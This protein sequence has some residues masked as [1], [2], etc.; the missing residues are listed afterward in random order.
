MGVAQRHGQHMNEVHDKVDRKSRKLFV[1]MLV[2]SFLSVPAVMHAGVDSSSDAL[3]PGEI[4]DRVD[5]VFRGE[6]S[7][8]RA[9]MTIVTKHW[10]RTLVI[11]FWSRGKEKSLI[12]ILEPA[13]ERGTATLKVGRELWNYLPKVNRV[14]KLPSSMMSASWMGSHF[15]NDDLVR[16]SRMSEDYDFEVSFE[17]KREGVEVV[18]LTCI[19]KEDAAVVWG[20]V[21]VLVERARYLPL[22]VLYHNEDLELMRTMTYSNVRELDGRALPTEI[23]I[24]PHDETGEKTRV[25]YQ[26]IDFD[27]VKDDELFSLRELQR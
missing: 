22:S 13:K 20:K 11:D 8:G 27:S 14:I 9:S 21:V 10:T 12:R 16:Q 24:V 1:A 7:V 23:V 4:L 3:T 6:S 15:T 5:D 19:P 25:E 18:E 26:T 17:G 2:A